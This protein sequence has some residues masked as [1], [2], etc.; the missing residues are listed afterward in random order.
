MIPGLEQAEFVRYGS[1]HRN[2][3][4][5]SP[6]L[7]NESLAWRGRPSLFFAG[8]IT[9]VEGYMEST[10]MGLLAGINAFRREAGMEPVVPP[11]ATA[12]GALIHHITHCASV[13]FQPMNVNF[14]LFPPLPGKARGREKRR[15][16]AK[17]AIEELDRWK[18][19]IE[20]DASSPR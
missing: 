6:R 19:A 2:T 18:Q 3:F 9:G 20:A 17:R 10:A 8:Q 15:L 4:I 14:G 12:M 11:P 16:L 13:P 1:V 7:L 5:D